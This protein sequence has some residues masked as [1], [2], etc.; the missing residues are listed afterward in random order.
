MLGGG[1]KRDYSAQIIRYNQ[2][3]EAAETHYL[4][5]RNANL[6]K[7]YISRLDFWNKKNESKLKDAL[8]FYNNFLKEKLNEYWIHPNTFF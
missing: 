8:Y 7:D 6:F 3:N 4:E 1:Q 5:K 2:I